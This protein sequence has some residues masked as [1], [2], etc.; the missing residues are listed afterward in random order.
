MATTGAHLVVVKPTTSTT[1]PFVDDELASSTNSLLQE[2]Q[3]RIGGDDVSKA[4]QLRAFE[5][6]RALPRHDDQDQDPLA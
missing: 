1:F 3:T 5:A 2:G 6:V 4:A